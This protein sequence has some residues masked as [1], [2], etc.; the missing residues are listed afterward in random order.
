MRTRFLT[1]LAVLVAVLVATTAPAW[2]HGD[3]GEVTL[4]KFEQTGPTT[5]DIEV[6]IVYEG[7]GHLAEDAKVTATLTGPGGASVGPVELA[8]TGDDTSLYAA[9]V[10]VPTSGEWNLTATAQEPEGEATGSLTVTESTPTSTVDPSTTAPPTT[11]AT[12]ATADDGA[13]AITTQQD[14]DEEESDDGLSPAVIVGACLLLAAVV[15]GG[16]FLVARARNA[17]DDETAPPSD[18]APTS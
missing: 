2:A 5:V 6:G 12:D 10:E 13:V 3:E 1:L 7:D 15:I 16:A 17:R 18:D 11:E 9:S 4:T 8:R 14:V